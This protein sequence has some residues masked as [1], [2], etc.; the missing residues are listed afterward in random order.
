LMG[1]EGFMGAR[2][3]KTTTVRPALFLKRVPSCHETAIATVT[4]AH[5][6]L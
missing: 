2:R 6:G 1:E 5:Q 4:G 3:G